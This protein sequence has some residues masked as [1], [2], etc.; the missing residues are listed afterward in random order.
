MQIRLYC[1]AP[2]VGDES[3]Q[4]A[5]RETWHTESHRCSTHLD[6][7]EALHAILAAELFVCFLITVYCSHC[8]HALHKKPAKAE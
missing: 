3:Q 8:D 1:R 2:W 5:A 4:A 7:G 6:R